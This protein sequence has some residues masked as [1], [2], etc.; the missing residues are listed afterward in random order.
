MSPGGI[1][2]QLHVILDIPTISDLNAMHERRQFYA[3]MSI[4]VFRMID[5]QV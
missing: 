2:F 4:F 1:V 3:S 5:G